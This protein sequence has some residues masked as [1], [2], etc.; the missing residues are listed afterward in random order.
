MLVASPDT[1][2]PV[3]TGMNPIFLLVGINLYRL[4]RVHGDEPWPQLLIIVIA[5]ATPC[6]RG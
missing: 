1:G 3:C 5:V 2:Y 4:P 6:A